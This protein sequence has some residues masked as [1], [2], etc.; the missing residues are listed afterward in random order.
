MRIGDE[1][2]NEKL[3]MYPVYLRLVHLASE[4]IRGNRLSDGPHG[5]HRR[6]WLPPLIDTRYP[7]G[8]AFQRP[9]AR[10]DHKSLRR[11][12]H[13]VRAKNDWAGRREEGVRQLSLRT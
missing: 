9:N 12:A 6:K 3:L 5:H 1:M 13:C 7:R 8:F 2:L 4:I 11:A 10:L